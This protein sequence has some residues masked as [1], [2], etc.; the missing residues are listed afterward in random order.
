MFAYSGLSFPGKN[1]IENEAFLWET[2][3]MVRDEEGTLYKMDTILTQPNLAENV[4]W[5]QDLN[6]A[7]S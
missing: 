3:Q 6:S 2:A 7:L 5:W 1:V 4:E